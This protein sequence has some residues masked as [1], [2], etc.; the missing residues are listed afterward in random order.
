M[1]ADENDKR[2]EAGTDHAEER[3]TTPVGP[4][5]P[6]DPAEHLSE[7]SQEGYHLLKENKLEEARVRFEEILETEPDNNYGLVGLGDLERRLHRYDQAVT[8]YLRCLERHPDNNYALFGLA[9]SYRELKMYNKAVE[10]WERYLQHDDRN[11]TVLT[12]VADAYR[13]ARNLERSRELY[14]K[15]LE[16]EENNAYALIGLGHLHYD[17]KEYEK[18]RFYWEQMYELS[19]DAVDIR[20]L[21]SLGNCHRKLK[22][23]AQ[24]IPYFE[25]AIKRDPDNFYA[26]Y[27]LADC[28]RGLH[29]A[30]RSLEYWQHL[31][32]LDGDNKVILT[33]AGDAYRNMG[34]LDNAEEYYH[35]ALNIAF[36]SYAVLGLAIIHRFRKRYEDAI[37]TLEDLI[38][39]DPANSRAVLELAGCYEDQRQI[40]EALAVLARHTNAVRHASRAIQR[41]IAELS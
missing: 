32:R 41:K 7:L 34:D 35:R 6:D 2:T 15:V 33:R 26:L 13:K 36:D 10:Y 1:K 21:T 30:E 39:R 17:F 3:D 38:N 12:R 20:V 14:L 11:V 27:G 24:G 19:G 29:Q 37:A 5:V 8:Y 31:L 25:E 23:Y 4:E 22:T 28:Y 16:I 9:E 40:P 18:A